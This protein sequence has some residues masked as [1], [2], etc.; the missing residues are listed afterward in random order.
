[1]TNEGSERRVTLVPIEG[2]TFLDVASVPIQSI[3]IVVGVAARHIPLAV[4]HSMEV[5]DGEGTRFKE[6]EF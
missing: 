6:S 4:H 3:A 5:D 2:T 1:M